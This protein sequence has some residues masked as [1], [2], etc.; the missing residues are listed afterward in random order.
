LNAFH[1]HPVFSDQFQT[2]ICVWKHSTA[3]LAVRLTVQLYGKLASS[4]S[5]RN[6]GVSERGSTRYIWKK[7]PLGA[8]V[9]HRIR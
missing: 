3:A 4:A 5:K 9:L 8:G 2:E 6:I 7:M 1:L